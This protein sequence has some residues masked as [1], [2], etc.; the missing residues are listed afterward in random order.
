MQAPLTT[1]TW[2]CPDE[3]PLFH[4]GV[5]VAANDMG[6]FPRPSPPP[7]PSGT[8]LP[9]QAQATCDIPDV[10]KM[11][12]QR[13]PEGRRWSPLMDV[14][15][16]RSNIAYLRGEIERTLTDYVNAESGASAASATQSNTQIIVPLDE[17]FF[18]HLVETYYYNPRWAYCPAEGLRI[19]N[20]VFIQRMLRLQYYSLRQ[21]QLYRKYFIDQNRFWHSAHERGISDRE[22]Q[23]VRADGYMLSH[24]WGGRQQ[25]YLAQTAGMVCPKHGGS[26]ESY[27]PPDSRPIPYGGRPQRE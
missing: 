25:Q 26:W 22:W 8:A 15:L 27:Y 2:A 24:P 20:N 6:Q 11:V 23:T 5:Y 12:L 3:A 7:P 9:P 4:S 17:D 19:L 1:D 10:R 14:F 21:R 16:S 13:F 18:E